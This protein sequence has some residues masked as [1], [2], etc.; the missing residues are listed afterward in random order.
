[1]IKNSNSKICE[2]Q[3]VIMSTLTWQTLTHYFWMKNE[4]IK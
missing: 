4:S 1:M 3:L 2:E